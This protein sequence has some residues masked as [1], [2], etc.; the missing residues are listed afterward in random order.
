MAALP[1]NT[2]ISG[3]SVSTTAPAEDFG[4]VG[5]WITVDTEHEMQ[6]DPTYTRPE[7]EVWLFVSSYIRGAA[8][9]GLAPIVGITPDTGRM[10]FTQLIY[11]KDSVPPVPRESLEEIDQGV[12]TNAAAL[13]LTDVKIDVETLDGTGI[14]VTAKKPGTVG[15]G[16]QC[17]GAGSLVDRLFST[18]D[19]RVLASMFAQVR[20]GGQDVDSQAVSPPLDLEQCDTAGG[21]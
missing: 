1:A 13:G 16:L 20:Q 11:A 17:S 12:R 3:A 9:A 14:A 7:W 21:T 19:R 15:L 18:Q 8:R 5:T 2:E 10:S 6:V 4:A